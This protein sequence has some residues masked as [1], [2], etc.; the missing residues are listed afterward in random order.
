MLS[1]LAMKRVRRLDRGRLID[2]VAVV[3]LVAVLG[4][5]AE[6]AKTV[7]LGAAQFETASLEAITQIDALRQKEVTA[8]SA[9]PADAGESFVAQVLGSSRPID[10]QTLEIL[11]DPMRGSLPQSE[12]AWQ[13]FLA[14][15]RG[16]Y[17]S[18]TAIFASLDRGSLFAAPEVGKAIPPLDPLIAQ[19]AAFAKSIQVH[20]ARFLRER[21]A[22]A[23]ELEVIRDDPELSAAAKRTALLRTRQRLLDTLAA[24][25]QI[26][27]ETSAQCLEAAR[28]GLEL[29]KLLAVYDRLTFEDLTEGLATAFRV[30]GSITGSDFAELEAR[31]DGVIAEIGSDPNMKALFDA[32]LARIDGVRGG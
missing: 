21:A 10:Q 26:T 9:S 32:A 8:T 23:A 12:A 25:A 4:G 3:A 13:A 14:T 30:A 27:R 19:M 2:F 6:K 7:Q 31:T 18:F 22:V 17:G 20:P 16:Q 15:L 29:R 1:E 11:A 24:E 28:L 5:C